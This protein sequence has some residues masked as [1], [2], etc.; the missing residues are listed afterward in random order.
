MLLPQQFAPNPQ[1]GEEAAP[2][3]EIENFTFFEVA[4]LESCENHSRLMHFPVGSFGNCFIS[5][6]CVTNFRGKAVCVLPSN[7]SEWIFQASINHSLQILDFLNLGFFALFWKIVKWKYIHRCVMSSWAC[8]GRTRRDARNECSSCSSCLLDFF[9]RHS[10][11]VIS[12]STVPCAL[13]HRLLPLTAC[14]RRSFASI[15]VDS[16]YKSSPVHLSN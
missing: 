8:M 1:N 6:P 11:I 3:N 2:R 15:V 9:L 5:F 10:P 13:F 16:K 14:F 12:I 4:S 7:R